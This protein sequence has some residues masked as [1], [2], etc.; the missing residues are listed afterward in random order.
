MTTKPQDKRT[1]QEELAHLRSS[2]DNIDAAVVHM[3]AER[4]KATKAVGELKAR[5]AMPPADKTREAQQIE[6][7]RRLAKEADLDPDFAEKFLNFI[8]TEVIRHHEKL[9]GKG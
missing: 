8:V 9:Q 4:F 2:I 3:L 1:P 6:R 5:H 7:L